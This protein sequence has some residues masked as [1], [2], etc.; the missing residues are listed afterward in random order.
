[1]IPQPIDAQFYKILLMSPW[2]CGDSCGG[3]VHAEKKIPHHILV[4]S[5]FHKSA[6]KSITLDSLK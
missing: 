3:T 6:R 4:Q 5:C 2:R 1:M